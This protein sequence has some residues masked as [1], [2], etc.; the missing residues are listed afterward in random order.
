MV[1]DYG[2]TSIKV[3]MTY[4]AMMLRDY[5]ILDLLSAAQELGI[6]TMVHAENA[7]VVQWMTERLEEKGLTGPYFHGVS[8]PPIVEAEATVSFLLSS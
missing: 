6:L 8:R 4:N 3:Y 7:D 5:Q 1:D 2:I